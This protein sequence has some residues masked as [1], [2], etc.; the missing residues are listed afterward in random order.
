MTGLHLIWDFSQSSFSLTNYAFLISASSSSF[1]IHCNV[2]LGS[3]LKEPAVRLTSLSSSHCLWLVR[4]LLLILIV[5]S[6]VEQLSLADFIAY[7]FLGVACFETWFTISLSVK[8][9]WGDHD[10]NPPLK[11]LKVSLRELSVSI[12]F[13]VSSCFSFA[14][15]SMSYVI[16]L[17]ADSSSLCCELM[18]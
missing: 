1:F 6:L 9:S 10:S 4:L 8:Y 15:F 13:R 12:V 17:I 7:P 16:L 18:L 5:V 11:L 14:S 3:T 2:S